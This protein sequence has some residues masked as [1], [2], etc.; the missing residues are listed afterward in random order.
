[1]TLLIPIHIGDK[2]V[3]YTNLPLTD[4]NKFNNAQVNLIFLNTQIVSSA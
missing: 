4:T 2:I 1:M 3:N